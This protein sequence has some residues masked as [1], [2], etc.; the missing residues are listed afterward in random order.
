MDS[1]ESGKK[2][3]VFVG[4]SFT[5][6]WDLNK[7]FPDESIVNKGIDGQYAGQLLLRFKHDVLD[8]HPEGVVIKL[9]E[10]NFS[11]FVPFKITQDNLIM[12]ATLAKA[13]GIKPYLASVIPVTREAD[14]KAESKKSINQQVHRFNKWLIQYAQENGF[15]YIDFAGAMSDEEGF[16]RPELTYD[17]VHPNEK[18]Y[19]IMA[20]VIQ[21]SIFSQIEK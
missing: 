1:T 16:L 10:M 18:G 13:N 8:L 2:L 4:A 5:A 19:Q 7:Y 6:N 20:T 12:M 17:G 3:L 11:H 21:S 15:T 9:C 14:K